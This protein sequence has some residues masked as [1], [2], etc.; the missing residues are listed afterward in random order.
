MSIDP[1]S[2]ED[3]K[4]AGQRTDNY[5]HHFHQN[6]ESVQDMKGREIEELMD[7]HSSSVLMTQLSCFSFTSV[8]ELWTGRR[9]QLRIC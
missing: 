1:H 3:E 5:C 6:S 2:P 8:P 9:W 7:T 4:G